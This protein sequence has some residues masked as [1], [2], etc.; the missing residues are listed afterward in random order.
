[1]KRPRLAVIEPL[2]NYRLKMTFINGNTLTVDK[3]ETILLSRNLRLCAIRAL[4][5]G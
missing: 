3:G 2:P 5:K 1:M 4:L